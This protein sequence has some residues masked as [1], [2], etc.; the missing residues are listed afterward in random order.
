MTGGNNELSL[1]FGVAVDAAGNLFVAEFGKNRVS[2]VSAGGAVSVLAGSGVAG[3]SGDG[4]AAASAM[5]KTPQGVAV[6]AAG[7]VYIADTGNNRVRV[8][9]G[10]NI[11]T[12][13]GN[14]SGGYDRDGVAA[15]S[16]QVGNPVAVAV[17]SSG[18]L[19]IA[20]GSARVRKVF[21]NGIITTIGGNGTRGYSGDGG[22]R[23]QRDPRHS[24]GARGSRLTAT[25]TSPT[26]TIV[27]CACCNPPPPAS[28]STR[29]STEPA[30]SRAPSHQVK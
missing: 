23:C 10:G 2:K 12:Y 18:S 22:S 17:D 25:S 30:I 21:P 26:P 24:F 27:R 20:D 9:S 5:L 19:Y 11:S 8:V 14:G 16:T 4:G 15:V 3:Y 28:R 29:L 6:D 7:N 13:A 1:P